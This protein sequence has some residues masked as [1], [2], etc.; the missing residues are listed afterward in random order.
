MEVV[1]RMFVNFAYTHVK[2]ATK[3]SVKSACHLWRAWGKT[4]TKN[5]VK[6][7]LMEK[8]MM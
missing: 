2:A 6:I 1:K 5:T 4:A 7:A 3:P 8:I